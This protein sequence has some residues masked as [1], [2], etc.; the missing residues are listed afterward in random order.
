M[1]VWKRGSLKLLVPF[2]LCVSGCVAPQA[3]ESVFSPSGELQAVVLRRD[4]GALGETHAIAVADQN[5]N[6]R[7]ILRIDAQRF[8]R[9][10]WRND[11]TLAI[12]CLYCQ[13]LGGSDR[14]LTIGESHISIEV[15]DFGTPGLSPR[16]RHLRLF[17]AGSDSQ[18]NSDEDG[19]LVF[20]KP[21]LKL[22]VGA[23]ALGDTLINLGVR[24]RTDSVMVQSFSIE[25]ASGVRPIFL[26]L[27]EPGESVVEGQA[28]PLEGRFSLKRTSK[29][30]LVW[31]PEASESGIFPLSASMTI[32][33]E[34]GKPT[35]LNF[36]IED[37]VRQE[38]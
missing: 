20:A 16:R 27:V 28:S 25:S 14:S 7:E 17:Q 30:V 38:E 35:T 26:G 18:I 19:R 29:L 36:E 15:N 6:Q 21:G 3:V 22:R 34:S 31:T 5:G 2:S 32:L 9:V 13:I 37:S 23:S 12:Y 24:A 10:E 4:S 8:L 11:E 33:D 1:N